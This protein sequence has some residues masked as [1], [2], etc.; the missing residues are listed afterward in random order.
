M[1]ALRLCFLYTFFFSFLILSR[2]FGLLFREILP[3]FNEELKPRQKRVY[4]RRVASSVP[5]CNAIEGHDVSSPA[6]RAGKKLGTR[7]ADVVRH[8]GREIDSRRTIDF[9]TQG[10]L[11]NQK[12]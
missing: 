10:L 6:P 12:I 7:A 3:K 8:V 5:C 1:S 9:E 11:K 2:L 4:K